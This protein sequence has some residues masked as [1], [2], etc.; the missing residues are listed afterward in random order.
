MSYFDQI[1]NNF[2]YHAPKEHRIPDF[3]IIREQA[4]MFAH[5]IDNLVPDGREKSLA[6][7]NL[8]TVVFW[9]NAGIAREET[10]VD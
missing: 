2:Q 9:V 6:L 3:K 5:V 4:R 7:T 1:E 10:S 8:E